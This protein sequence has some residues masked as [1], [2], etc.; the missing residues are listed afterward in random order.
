V[1]RAIGLTDDEVRSS[2]RFGLGRFNTLEDIDVT[3][4]LLSDAV[5][6]LRGMAGLST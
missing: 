3:V 5:A 1:L 4:Q 6:R 2:L